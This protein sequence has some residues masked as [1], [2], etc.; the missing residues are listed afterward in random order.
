MI[1]AILTGIL[2]GLVPAVSA[3]QPNLYDAL[4][5]RGTAG[6]LGRRAAQN[7]LVVT[8]VALT[9][10][11]LVA[12]GLMVRS[13]TAL[14]YAAP[15]FKPRDVLTFYTRLSPEHATSP[16]KVRAALLAIEEKMAAVPGV[17]STSVVGVA[18]AL[19]ISG[20][21]RNLLYGVSPTD[22]ATIAIVTVLLLAVTLLAC[23]VPAQRATRV[24]PLVALRC[25]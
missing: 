22:P 2:F 24:D 7:L 12:A 6:R 18:C 8:E 9:L 21:L 23:Y 17:E 1:L 5:V 15:G 3:A 13:L 25:E 11:L 19:T 10:M 14:L 20:L 4:K 16:A